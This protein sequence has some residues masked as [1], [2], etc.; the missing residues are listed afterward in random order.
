MAGIERVGADAWRDRVARGNVAG[1]HAAIGPDGTPEVR[2]VLAGETPRLLAVAAPG[3]VVPTLVDLLP[4][5]WDER[6][7]ADLY[8]LRFEGHDPHRALVHHPD[9]RDLWA[10]PV[11]GSDVHTVPVGPVHAGVIESGHFLFHVVGERVLHVDA[12]LF[13]KHRGLERH[14]EG[15]SPEDAG[16]VLSRVCAG[17]AV[18]NAVAYAAATED[19][20]GRVPGEGTR[21]V[22]T[23]LIELERMWNHLN[24]V[25]QICAGVG[26][27]PGTMLF[28][29]L[30]ERVQRVCALLTGHRFMFDAVTLASAP[31]DPG[32]AAREAMRA[33]LAAVAADAATAARG[34]LFD[35]SLRDRTSG[36]GR[37]DADAVRELGVVGPAARAA[38]VAAD[39]RTDAPRLWYPGFAAVVP[40]T[41]AGDVAARLEARWVELEQAAGIVGELLSAPLRPDAPADTGTGTGHGVGIAESPRG[42]TVCT[43]EIRGGTVRR[44]HLRTGS[45][46]NWPA[47]AV[48]GT[49]AILP[50]FPLVNKSFELCYACVDR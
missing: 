14:A 41:P 50:D 28:A 29:T 38:G 11:V 15:R 31:G 4:A 45:Y 37:I 44:V 12:R 24:D 35:T 47:V 10:T 3:G 5:G 27:A 39:S 36:P 22:R 21:R 7:A 46:A 2:A 18:T 25:S 19:A 30:K 20:L 1:L 16:R 13:H 42:R 17:C 23:L 49:R 32:D 26:L 48:A 33:E 34:L 9:D 6:E 40:P 43:V 8:G